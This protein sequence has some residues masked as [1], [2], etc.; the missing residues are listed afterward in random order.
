MLDVGETSVQVQG[1]YHVRSKEFYLVASFE[2]LDFTGLNNLF[3]HLFD[4]QLVEPDVPILIGAA[5]LEASSELGLRLHVHHVRVGEHVVSEGVFE[6][7]TNG[8]LLKAQLDEGVATVGDF[9]VTKAYLSIS[10]GRSS[11]IGSTTD[12]MLGGEVEWKG[13]TI[14]VGVHVCISRSS[15]S[16]NQHAFASTDNK[17]IEREKSLEYTV[18]GQFANSVTNNGLLLADLIPELKGTFMEDVRLE[19]AAIIIASCD[20]GQL[21]PFNK[22]GYSVR[23]G[24]LRCLLV[25]HRSK[26]FHLIV[27]F[28]P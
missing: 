15:G 6:I 17:G 22:G 1:E 13:W 16:T 19:G 3:E 26:Q 5:T 11:K 24:E 23:Q 21:G 10:F 2:R 28:L 20:N 4:E 25:C 27:Q 12:V 14:D 9:L 7:G 8:V 18:Y